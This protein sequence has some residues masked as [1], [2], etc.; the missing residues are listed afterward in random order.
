[1]R[2]GSYEGLLLPQVP[3]EYHWDRATFLAETCQKAGMNATCWRDENTD[4]FSFTALVF[5]DHHASFPDSEEAP[6]SLLPTSPP[7]QIRHP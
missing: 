7:G 2:N 6:H 5:D 1:M 3:T 4:I